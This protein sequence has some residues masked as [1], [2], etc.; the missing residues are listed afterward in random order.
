MSSLPLLT[1]GDCNA[2]SYNT[3]ENGEFRRIS[4]KLDDIDDDDDDNVPKLG[5]LQIM[6]I[7]SGA[8]AYGGVMSTYFLLT[9]PSECS[10]F[11]DGSSIALGVFVGIAGFSQLVA[12]IVGL[13][14]DRCAHRM[15]RRRPF[16]IVGGVISIVGLLVQQAFS[17][18]IDVDNRNWYIY[19]VAFFCTMIGMNTIFAAMIALIP[20]LVPNHQIGTA[21]GFEA[22][23]FVSGSLF[24]FASFNT[25]LNESLYSIY[26]FYIALN[27]GCVILTWMYANEQPILVQNVKDQA[28]KNTFREDT[29]SSLDDYAYPSSPI[30]WTQVKDSFFISPTDHHDFFFVTVSRTFYYMG[31]SVQTFFLYYLRDIIK[32]TDPEGSMAILAVVGQAFGAIATVPIGMISDYCGKQRKPYVFASCAI[33]SITNFSLLYIRSFRSV[34]IIASIA[35]IA[36]GAYLTMDTSLAMD[37]LPNSDESARMLGVWGVA[38]FIGSALGPMIGGPLLFLTSS[39]NGS[40]SLFGYGLLFF[41]S[42]LYYSMS[43]LILT[44]VNSSEKR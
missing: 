33:L 19:V 34:M 6:A 14:S 8:F 17:A 21:N 36:N 11:G 4:S 16:V 28:Q 31:I 25:Y 37:T 35:G 9:L 15:G 7:L 26:N 44:F 29:I 3:T 18:R 1:K 24:G 12:P 5:V 43:A 32:V 27:F 39:G 13:I 22:L 23:L 30:T 2:S 41:L 42:A 40:Y 38:M 20:D 10:V